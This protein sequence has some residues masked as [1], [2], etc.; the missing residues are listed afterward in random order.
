M[1]GKLHDSAKPA[2]AKASAGTNF[3]KK[4]LIYRIKPPSRMET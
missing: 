1:Q 4:R 3:S 2:E